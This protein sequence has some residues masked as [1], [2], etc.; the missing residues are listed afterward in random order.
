M[1]SEAIAGTI[2]RAK[3]VGRNGR[4]RVIWTVCSICGKG[5]W[6]QFNKN[7]IV[8]KLCSDCKYIR[9]IKPC[10]SPKIG[11]IRHGRDI[12]RNKK[13]QEAMQYIWAACEICG[14]E[15]WV[16]FKNGQADN[17]RCIKC[18]KY[19]APNIC[20]NPEIGEIR[21]GR[22]IGMANL[23]AR[24]IYQKCLGCEK[25]RWVILRNGKPVSV[26]CNTCI[27]IF[28]SGDR[29]YNRDGYVDILVSKDD[30]Y[31]AM[32]RKHGYMA[33][34]RYVMAKHIGRCLYKW[35]VVHH[36]NGIRDD[37]RIEN[38]ELSNSVSDHIVGHSKGYRDGYEKGLIDGKDKQ[39]QE[40]KDL[41]DNQ[42]KQ[43]RLL[44]WQVNNRV[45]D[46]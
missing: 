21:C 28:S 20:I 7:A 1:E 40:L 36:K 6:V 41:I 24:Y 43:I 31:Y 44:L 33:E 10:L 37:N 30:P 27:N 13:I 5:R 38:L 9:V 32:S 23:G 4:G 42:G 25:P 2:K 34:H 46:I 3:E 8:G 45:G 19:I 18:A 16:R 22:D 12:G 29:K 14:K 26:K 35:E 15:R 11:D 39:I 17:K